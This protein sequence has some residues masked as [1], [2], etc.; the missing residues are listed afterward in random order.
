MNA[1]A[2]QYAARGRKYL[3]QASDELAR[4]DLEQAS[5]RGWGAAAQFA[6]AAAE[7]RDWPHGQ[8]RQ[9]FGV[10]RRLSDEVGERDLQVQFG[11]ASDLHA[12]FYEGFLEQEDV[13]FHLEHV[14]LFV[15]RI[16]EMLS[17]GAA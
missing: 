2:A 5:E 10:V 4:D 6:K 13:L 11:L 16:E 7:Q 17:S 9:L 8:H 3:A 12:N 14:T 1:A 15:D